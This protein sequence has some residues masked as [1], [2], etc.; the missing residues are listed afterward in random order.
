MHFSIKIVYSSIKI[1]CIS[2]SKLYVF[3]HLSFKGPVSILPLPL[4]SSPDFC[5][6]T[7]PQTDPRLNTLSF[8]CEDRLNKTTTEAKWLN[9]NVSWRKFIWWDVRH[10]LYHWWW[11]RDDGLSNNDKC[12]CKE[13]G[14]ID[15]WLREDQEQL[16]RLFQAGSVGSHHLSNLMN[17]VWKEEKFTKTPNDSKYTAIM[18][19]SARRIT[20]CTYIEFIVSIAITKMLNETKCEWWDKCW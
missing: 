2:P 7:R 11:L 6:D 14:G 16:W 19:A 13:G 5:C 9:S 17:Y 18:E 15:Q 3:P 1:V 10:I 8:L 12:W 20:K 4:L